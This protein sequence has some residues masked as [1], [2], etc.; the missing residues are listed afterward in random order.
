MQMF[1]LSC[2]FF[3]Y[4][5]SINEY[6]VFMQRL[7]MCEVNPEI[8]ERNLLNYGKRFKFLHPSSDSRWSYS[9]RSLWLK[10]NPFCHLWVGVRKS[11][12][13]LIYRKL[14]WLEVCDS[15]N[16]AVEDSF[17]FLGLYG[18]PA[19]EVPPTFHRIVLLLTS[20]SNSPL[21]LLED[22]DE[23]SRILRNVRW[24]LPNDTA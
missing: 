1:S 5:G 17:F 9:R 14:N 21:M 19:D 4:A 6:S 12:V 16:G 11:P 15:Y 7:G 8:K 18:V 2:A 3:L 20:R 13:F 23:S 24:F 10:F 22:E